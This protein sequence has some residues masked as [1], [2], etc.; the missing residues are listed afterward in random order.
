ME[1]KIALEVIDASEAEFHKD[2]ATGKMTARVTIIK[3]GRAK[4]PRNYRSSAIRKAAKEGIY[5]G[6]RM[7][8]NHSDKPPI[9]RSLTELVSAVESTEYDPKGDRII[10]SIEFFDEKF[11]D[12]ASRARKHMGVSANH[13]IKVQKVRESSGQIIDD[14][15]EIVGAHSVDWVVYPS[16]GGE[17]ISFAKES[18][19]A[20][21]VEWDEVTLDQLKEKAPAVLAAYKSELAKE[22]VGPEDEPDDDEGE[23]AKNKSVV[24][25]QEAITKLVQ[26]QVTSIT[27]AAEVKRTKQTETAKKVREFASKSG[28]HT[29]VQARIINQFVDAVEYIESDV[30]EA[31]DDAKAELK[32][33]GFGPRIT[34]MG[35]TGN[36][37]E[38]E[39]KVASVRESVES[40]F[41]FDKKKAAAG[42]G[43]ES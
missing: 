4:N 33:L 1:P 41:G 31:V 28:L 16:A 29:R 6:M 2:E 3:G 27:S 25:T 13:R 24:M 7:F 20:D 39:R 19:G 21:Q 17:I 35:S 34:G 38:G 36:A 15:E 12:Y 22:S 10:G 32:E 42:A 8:V 40:V 9:R 37:Q 26:E 23:S 30:K 5:N 18:E 11:Y 14:V 43:K